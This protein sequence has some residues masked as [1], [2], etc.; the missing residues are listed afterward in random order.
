MSE[1]A[2]DFYGIEQFRFYVEGS[3]FSAWTDHKTLQ[4]I[5]NNRQKLTSKR[6][7]KH[8]DTI[9]D[10]DFKMGYLRGADMPCDYG[11]KHPNPILHLSSEEQ[12]LLGF[13]NGR[14][15]YVRKI[16]NLDNFPN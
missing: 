14:D 16:I 5:Y 2:Y 8:R 1:R 10:L 7:A 4:S 6:I 9:H 12:E 3:H 15:I 11:S 13:D